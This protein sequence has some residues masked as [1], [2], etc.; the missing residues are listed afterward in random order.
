MAKVRIVGVGAEGPTLIPDSEIRRDLRVSRMTIWRWDHS[1]AMAELGWPPPVDINKRKHRNA[2]G[3]E[4]FKSKLAKES[5]ARRHAVLEAARQRME[6][7][8]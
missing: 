1:T 8:T 7:V 4:A 5:I 6:S 3:Y 2:T